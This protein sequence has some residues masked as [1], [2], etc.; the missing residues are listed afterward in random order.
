MSHFLSIAY[1]NLMPYL[2][3]L[4]FMHSLQDAIRPIIQ[5]FNILRSRKSI[6]VFAPASVSNVGPGFDIMGFALE[7]PG[8]EV[9]VSTNDSDKI[10]ITDITGDNGKLS[11]DTEL[12]TA[13][14]AIKALF[15]KMKISQGV[16]VTIHKKM[17][18]G[19]GLG[20]SAASAV[21]GVFAVNLLLDLNLSPEKLLPFALAGEALASGAIHADN[22]APSLF[23]G[24]LLIRDYDPVDIIKIPVPDKLYCT[25]IYPDIV[26]KTSDA[27]QILP[28]SFTMKDMIAQAGNAAALI[29]GLSSGNLE[30]VGRSLVDRVAEP[31]R[32]GLIPF[33]DN[34]RKKAFSAG[35][36]NCNISGSGPSLFCFS[37]SLKKAEKL[38]VVLGEFVRG[39]GY[40]VNTYVSKINNLGPKVLGR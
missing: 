34:L 5:E 24:F 26:I 8:D 20:S 1:I 38:A 37:G 10:V 39:Q 21:A 3:F 13:T 30:L 17:G 18:I 4:I 14:V 36:L 9:I 28:S 29:A 19:S 7:K 32:A 35:A 22:V 40:G 11:R 33:Y 2:G 6:K 12:N 15:D 25:I 16:D 23:G 27:R 31:Y